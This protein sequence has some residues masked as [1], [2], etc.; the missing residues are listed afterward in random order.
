V[1]AAGRQEAASVNV[2]KRIARTGGLAQGRF[3]EA[4][5]CLCWI[6]LALCA[7]APAE[8][9][10]PDHGPARR[11]IY[12]V[13]DYG[14]MQGDGKADATQAFQAAL[15]AASTEVGGGL[16]QVP[17][18]QF[19]IASHLNVPDNVTLE[20][21]WR[22]PQRGDPVTAG[23]VLLAVE[24]AGDPDGAPFIVLNTQSTLTGITI[25]Y[26]EQVKANPPHPYPWT[27]AT[28]KFCDNP[29]IINVTMINPYQAVDFGS[30]PT[31]RHFINGLYAY[32]LY[33]GLY[34]NQCYDVGRIENI[35]FWPFW[36]LDPNSPLWEFTRTKGTA[37]I[38]GKTDGEMASN[39]FSIFYN[40]GMHFIRGPIAEAASCR[41]A[42]DYD[43]NRRE[44]KSAP[45]SGVYTNCYMDV[46]PCAIKVD[47]VASDAGVSFVNGMFMS[48]VEVGANNK[49]QVK[50][51]ACGFWAN[52][53]LD[54]HA[55]V[56]GRGTVL[57]E[58]CHFSNW[59]QAGAGAPCIDANSRQVLVNGCEFSSDRK[60][61]VKVRLGPLVQ[62]GIVTSNIMGG[63]VAVDNQ[64]PPEAAIEIAHNAGNTAT[65][66]I[67]NWIVLGPFPNPAVQNPAQGKP[68]RTGCDVDY[69]APIGGE[70]QAVLTPATTVSYKDE[71]GKEA[72]AT[73]QT[74]EAD[75][76]NRIDFKSI[77]Q[78]G[79]EVAYAFCYIRSDRDEKAHFQLG[80]ND[81]SK[82]WVNGQQ[83]H[84]FFS[85]EGG[86]DAPGSYQFDAELH[87]GLNPVLI[88]VEDAGGSRWS[89]ILEVFDTRGRPL[90]GT[91]DFGF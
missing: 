19:L 28:R 27:V 25:F 70:A 59:D 65:A 86:S 89:F 83:A 30:Y 33:K 74:V 9:G 36:D 50:F 64:A 8:E 37:F 18:G 44:A 41:P 78:S 79:K 4:A 22:S 72:T 68:S 82:V 75:K 24:G 73:A 40:V 7:V 1:S 54:S 67:R 6:L 56:E 2:D 31:G 58:S 16:V 23:T 60:N 57:F 11:G 77:F 81:G 20:G 39:C 80:A 51:T 76:G 10:R 66:F 90:M 32:P 63:G 69:L 45:G 38:I 91:Q 12:N 61:H 87:R 26:P 17:A 62:A 21:I 15:D 48:T 42:A 46:T 53:G 85:D 52:R 47:E 5:P 84:A 14:A 3:R 88:K 55:K 35:H 43:D 34:I 29:T 13:A 49:G 71:Q